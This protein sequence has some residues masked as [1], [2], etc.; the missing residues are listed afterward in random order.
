MANPKEKNQKISVSSLKQFKQNHKKITALTAYDF[1]TAKIL[2][3]AGL[4]IILVGDSLGNVILG[5]EN[6]LPVTM[7]DML[8]HLKAVRRAVK[9]SL[10]VVD[11]PLLGTRDQRPGTRVKNI[12][13][14]IDAGAEAVKIEG[15]EHLDLIK[16]CIKAGIPVMGH[17][18]FTPQD[19]EKLGGAKMQGKT[20]EAAEKLIKDAKQ[21]EAAGVFA[22]V[23][24]LVPEDVATQITAAVEI[25]TIG[26]GA[27]RHTDG[28]V[29]VLHDILGLTQGK[30]PK[31]VKQYA[32]LGDLTKQA[33]QSY[34]RD[35]TA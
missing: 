23:I 25:P 11:L 8:H 22:I 21:L 3:E 35:V 6:T 7:A 19:I 4:D 9:K 10:L 33:V 5:Y 16:E 1:P 12:L 27:G 2:D 24:E 15:L 30:T 26:I 13:K 17:I 31:F 18:G 28:Q 34:I 14:L 29:L 32:N 20:K